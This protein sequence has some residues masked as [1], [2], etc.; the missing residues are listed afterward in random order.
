MVLIHVVVVACNSA[1]WIT[2]ALGYA[3]AKLQVN[4][5]H[6]CNAGWYTSDIE[7]LFLKFVYFEIEIQLF[8]KAKYLIYKELLLGLVAVYSTVLQATVVKQLE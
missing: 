8:C 2:Q 6:G 3:V 5:D 1:T 4:V 7:M